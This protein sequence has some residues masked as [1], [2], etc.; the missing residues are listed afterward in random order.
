MQRKWSGKT[1]DEQTHVEARFSP[2]QKYNAATV[3]RKEREF[4]PSD[5]AILLTFN[6]WSYS[7]PSAM[8]SRPRMSDNKMC[9]EPPC[10][11]GVGVEMVM[12]GGGQQTGRALFVSFPL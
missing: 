5:R 7:A 12:S 2:K 3:K 1:N 4:L 9:G 11:G 10:C 6:K 8:G